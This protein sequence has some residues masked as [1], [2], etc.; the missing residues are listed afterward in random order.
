MPN[1]VEK[2]QA[3]SEHF[4]DGFLGLRESYSIIEPMLFDRDVVKAYCSASRTRGFRSIRDRLFLICAQDI[5]KQCLDG[6][7]N[8]P[9]IFKIVAALDSPTLLRRLS[10]NYSIWHAAAEEDVTDSVILAALAKMKKR[11]EGERRIQFGA[12]VAKLRDDWSA[13]LNSAALEAFKNIRNKLSAHTD[14]QWVKVKYKTLNVGELGLK[15]GDLRTT[16]EAMQVVVAGVG[17]VVRAADFARDSLDH[18]L[19]KAADG[20]WA[21]PLPS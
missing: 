4:L 5:A 3:H 16:I 1:Q 17:M 8:S 10:D 12:H 21:V 19:K 15:F 20:F 13:L 7:D 9:S 18:Q 11:N 14:V 2:I 6:S